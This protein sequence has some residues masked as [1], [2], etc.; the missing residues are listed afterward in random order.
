MEQGLQ[1]VH[2]SV[3]AAPSSLCRALARI[4]HR[5]PTGSE[6]WAS[7]CSGVGSSRWISAPC[8]AGKAQPQLLEHLLTPLHQ[9]GVCRAVLPHS[10]PLSPAS[11]AVGSNIFPFLF[12]LSPSHSVLPMGSARGKF[13][14]VLSERRKLQKFLTGATPAKTFL[15]KP[16]GAGKNLIGKGI[17]P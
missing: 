17:L 10:S 11:A 14:L 8:A 9:P 16:S 15:S 6:L 1:L 2:H 5:H 12:L 13:L 7:P 3:S 4:Q